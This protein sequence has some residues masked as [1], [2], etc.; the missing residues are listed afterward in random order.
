[1][2]KRNIFLVLLA[3]LLV[4]ITVLSI[5][6][7]TSNHRGAGKKQAA[8]IKTSSKGSPA[9][10]G[11]RDKDGSR[12]SSESTATSLALEKTKDA[13]S[14]ETAAGEEHQAVE[15]PAIAPRIFEHGPRA[16]HLV[17]LTFDLCEA[18]H[19]HAGFD[20]K[21]IDILTERKASATFFMGGKW[22]ESHPQNAQSLAQ[23]PLFEIE[24][25]S[26]S[27]KV[28]TKIT[29]EEAKQQVVR[30]QHSINLLTGVTPKYFRFP[31]GKYTPDDLKLVGNCGLSAIQWDVVT[32][33]P[34][35]HI[36]A[37]AIIREV[38]S[39]A[40]GGSIV[41]MHANGR[42]W[43]TAEALPAV[44][45]NLRSDGY[46]LVTVSKLLSGI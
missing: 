9:S 38:K 40:R 29:D 2:G 5:V 21:I 22:A 12:P 16:T 3:L 6:V 26:Y 20:Q 7:V 4:G 15:L 39:K 19:D 28:F 37:A 1:M 18:E 25:H 46:Q 36:S 42:G 13:L 44:I 8:A 24:N 32:G 14:T 35:K 34:D 11:V 43:H 31:A 33:D 27:H 10:K 30:A 41:I 45:D 23:N 17:A